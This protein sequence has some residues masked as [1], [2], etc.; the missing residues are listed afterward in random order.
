MPGDHVYRAS[1]LSRGNW[2][3]PTQVVVTPS[4]VLHYKPEIVG[5]REQTIHIAHIS[6]VLI[7]RNLFFSDVLIETSGGHNPVRCHGHR[8]RDAVAI[9]EIIE[10]NR[11]LRGWLIFVTHDVTSHP[12]RY[13]CTPELFER[14]V[15][16]S[17]ESGAR[18]LPVAQA[19]AEVAG[20][21]VIGATSCAAV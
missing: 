7:D 18:I 13:G 14:V 11:T 16:W 3:Y 2:L 19:L 6:S 21:P 17:A 1:R 15:G 5:G 8:K 12:S 20:G 9:K 4:S 10:R